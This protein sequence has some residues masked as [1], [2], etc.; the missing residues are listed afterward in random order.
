MDN[1]GIGP[2]TP[3][4]VR[5][6]ATTSMSVDPKVLFNRSSTNR[7]GSTNVPSRV[8]LQQRNSTSGN[9]N[10]SALAMLSPVG[11]ASKNGEI[12]LD[13]EQGT[14]Q[15]TTQGATDYVSDKRKEKKPRAYLEP[16]LDISPQIFPFVL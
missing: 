9:G 2:G 8:V 15:E 3:A 13:T 5:R 16:S 4:G 1:M 11:A 6:A 14:T 12:N 10:R 7:P